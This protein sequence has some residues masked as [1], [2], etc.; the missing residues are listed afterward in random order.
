MCTVQLNLDFLCLLGLKEVVWEIRSL[1]VLFRMQGCALR[2]PGC[3]RR[4]TFA[5]GQPDNLF[6]FIIYKLYAGH[7]GSHSLD[8][9]GSF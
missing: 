6:S 8:P 1:D 4:L 7:P 2:A 3:L 9:L 5:I